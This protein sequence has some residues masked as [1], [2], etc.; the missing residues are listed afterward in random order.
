MNRNQDKN[1]VYDV[2]ATSNIHK[3]IKSATNG[4]IAI[5][6]RASSASSTSHRGRSIKARE[7]KTQYNSSRP[8]TATHRTTRRGMGLK[9]ASGYDPAYLQQRRQEG[10]EP[11]VDDEQGHGVNTGAAR[12]VVDSGGGGGGGGG[13]VNSQRKITAM[14]PVVLIESQSGV[15]KISGPFVSSVRDSAT[16]GQ[17][18][19]HVS[20]TT[21]HDKKS[22]E[23]FGAQVS[24]NVNS[25]RENSWR[26]SD[27][28]EY[29]NEG[30]EEDEDDDEE[31]YHTMGLVCIN[32][33]FY[34]F[35]NDLI[36]FIG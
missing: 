15:H 9:N 12:G 35:I 28:E 34:N 25:H 13:G 31:G 24:F 19:V 10:Q 33:M 27:Q 11:H 21:G 7:T 18:D 36:C 20:S 23:L 30:D 22:S 26:R 8:S 4:N 2:I 1:A 32:S 16:G 17:N 3:V 5:T 29:N 14:D 6:N